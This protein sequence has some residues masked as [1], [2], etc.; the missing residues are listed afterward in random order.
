M[1]RFDDPVDTE[2]DLR[3]SCPF[4]YDDVAEGA[5]EPL[6]SQLS[7]ERE[8]FRETQRAKL[9][10]QRRVAGEVRPT[11]S[12]PERSRAG[13]GTIFPITSLTSTF[14]P[15]HFPFHRVSHRGTHSRG[16]WDDFGTNLRRYNIYTVPKVS[17]CGTAAA[18]HKSSSHPA[19]ANARSMIAFQLKQKVARKMK[20]NRSTHAGSPAGVSAM[21]SFYITLQANFGQSRI[22][23]I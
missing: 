13:S 9:A 21:T 19:K 18:A 8:K 7:P 11:R 14:K 23:Y 12:T 1:D 15:F 22:S 4:L 3:E 17:H 6:G 5:W 2:E 16:K 20:R 10:E